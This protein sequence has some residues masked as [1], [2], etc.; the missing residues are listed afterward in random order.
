MI[1]I[2]MYILYIL[3]VENI[4]FK[5]ILMKRVTQVLRKSNKN[6]KSQVLNPNGEGT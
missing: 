2:V 1:L 3:P 5:R 4:E 6:T